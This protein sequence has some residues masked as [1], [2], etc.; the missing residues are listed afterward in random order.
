MAT[1]IQT[2]SL[3][4]LPR[5]FPLPAARISPKAR[6]KKKL[7]RR[8]ERDYSQIVRRTFQVVFLAWN[9]YLGGLF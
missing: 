1:S 3:T 9:V 4:D 2:E 6:P 8:I 7:V 5:T